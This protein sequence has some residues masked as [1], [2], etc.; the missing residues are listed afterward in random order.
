MLSPQA[1]VREGLLMFLGQ[2][3]PTQHTVL[4]EST[5]ALSQTVTVEILAL[6]LPAV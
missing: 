3:L 6:T 2:D 5:C 1:L 4:L